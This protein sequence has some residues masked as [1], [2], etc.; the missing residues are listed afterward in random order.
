MLLLASLGCSTDSPTAPV[1]DN[2]PNPT[3]TASGNWNITIDVE[4]RELVVDSDQPATVTVR[5]R[6]VASGAVPTPGTTM[7]IA[8]SLGEFG[9]LGSGIQSAVLSLVSGRADLLLFAGS[10]IGDLVLT[11]QLE[12][13]VGRRTAQIVPE[14]E[15]IEASFE[16]AVVELLVTFQDT[17]TGSP[18]KWKWDFGDG[19]KSN[20]QNP[21][22]EYAEAG[23]YVVTLTA[24]KTGS[25]DT[26]NKIVSVEEEALSPAFAFLVDGFNVTFQDLSGGEP[27]SWRWSFGDG[28]GSSAQHPT[29]RYTRSGIYVVELTVRRG[30]VEASTSQLVS[31]GDTSELSA[32]FSAQVDGFRVTFLDTSTGGPT[33]WSWTF[34]DGA[35][36]TTQ[37]PTHTYGSAGNYP[38]TLTVRRSGSVSTT[39]QIVKVGEV[40]GLSASFSFQVTGFSAT[41]LD[42]SSGEPT[43]WK[44]TFGDGGTSTEQNP[45]HLYA[46]AGNYAVTMTASRSGASDT[47]SQLVTVQ[48]GDTELFITAIVPN[49][50][51]PG[52]GTA[53]TITGQNFT[54]PL[55]V[56]FGNKLA[57]I[58]SVTSTT[59]MVTTPPGDITTVPCD[60]DD[61]GFLDGLRELDL[62]VDVGVELSDGSSEEISNGFTYDVADN[63]CMP[64]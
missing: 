18:T 43:S 5:V 47:T 33:S 39:S 9:S 1:Q 60:T 15:P 11:G 12:A 42:T 57:T 45:T 40:S 31:V 54:S 14:I 17:S 37:H 4:P 48:E 62:P 32:A 3:P 34:G 10:V 24:S 23:N 50:G 16:E 52:G 41:F 19:K 26:V 46:A 55:R 30:G 51:A 35:T 36:S 49:S 53:V 27:T 63:S 25:S 6:D 44:W 22:H 61:D 2:S 7:V 29:H 38:V 64:G 8:T 21:V 28:T 13:S 58:V 56:L 59:I 20:Q